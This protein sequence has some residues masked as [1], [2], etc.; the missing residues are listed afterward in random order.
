MTVKL[1]N[2]RPRTDWHVSAEH[3]DDAREHQEGDGQRSRN[4]AEHDTRGRHALTGLGST[5]RRDLAL[6]HRAE[7]H[8]DD[9][10]GQ[11]DKAD[12]YPQ[13]SDDSAGQRTDC[14]AVV[15]RRDRIRRDPVPG[16]PIWGGPV[17]ARTV[18]RGRILPGAILTRRVLTGT[19]LACLAGPVLTG[20]VLTGP[21]YAG[22]SSGVAVRILR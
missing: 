12:P 18:G 16:G 17:L 11:A 2:D 6:G 13:D 5:R 15:R 22:S 19:V 4:P 21:G 1:Q 10:D 14:F 7:D 20:T 9:A 3:A 8:R